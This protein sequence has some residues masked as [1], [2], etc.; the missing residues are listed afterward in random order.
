MLDKCLKLTAK[1]TSGQLGGLLIFVL[2]G[3][4]VWLVRTFFF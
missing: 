4:V 3:V 2:L 1:D